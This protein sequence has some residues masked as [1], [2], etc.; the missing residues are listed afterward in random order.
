MAQTKQAKIFASLR[1]LLLLPIPALWC[2]LDHYGKL[3]FL[4]N[5]SVDWRFQVRGEIEAP[6]KIVYA[7]I[8][9]LSLNQIGGFPW[10]RSY[11]ATVAAAL[12]NEAKVKAVG[13]DVVFSDAGISESVNRKKLVEGNAE[14]GRYLNKQPPVVLAAAYGGWQFLDVNGKRKERALPIMAK[15][16]RK[17]DD[18]EPPETPSFETSPDPDKRRPYTPPIAVGLIDTMGGGTRMVPAWTPSNIKKTYYHMSLELARLYWGLPAG[19][20]SHDANQITFKNPDGSVFTTVPLV[21]GQLLEINWFTQW[22]SPQIA[23]TTHVEFS[24]LYTYA[25]A[26]ASKDPEEVKAGKEFFAQG[27]FKDAVVLVGPVDPLLQDVAPTSMDDGPVP[28]VSV[29]GNLLKTIVSEQFLRHLEPRWNYFIVFGLAIVVTTLAVAGGARALF[30][31]VM[32]VLTLVVFLAATFHLFKESHIV[33]P[34]TA[35]LGAALTMS[36][37]GLIWQVIDEQKAKGRIKG[38]FGAYVSP[39]LVDRMIDSGEDPQLGGHDDEI[40]AYFS[41]IQGFSSFSE[42]L[43]SGPLVELM[44]E[45][46]TACTDIVQAQGGTLDKYIGDAVVAMFGAPIPLPDHAYRACVATQLV[47]QKL[48]ELREKWKHEGEKWPEIVWK[49]QSRIGLNTGVCMIGNMG[50]R[51]R[52]NYTMMGDN[53]NLAARMESGAKS[54]GA[55][56]MVAEAAKLGCQKHDNGRVVF[57][58]LGRIQVMGRS[59]AVPIF[60]I[61]GLKESLAP[62]APECIGLFEQGLARY[63]ARDW[64]G[65]I[66]LFKQSVELE[67]NQPGKTPGVKTNPSLVYIGIAEHYKVVP[68][69]SNWEGVYVMTEK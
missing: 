45:Y 18:I 46:L 28:K 29:H 30:A 54:W 64:D 23:D 67:P 12:V 13:F 55:Y 24:T 20:I 34:F 66:A 42:K 17:L 48:G 9:T 47:H 39:Q 61:V 43:G 3:N 35:P 59:Q 33:L 58:A 4:E 11:F 56:T 65:A 6:L 2:V 57:R 27:E 41:D 8:D 16:T 25:A 26:L 38:M 49:M 69:P 53:V 63:Y 19:S 22:Y 7:D 60:E 51:T 62:T 37:A 52:F 10:S 14:F 40:T 15:E 1:W 44:N 32:A 50:S 5:R 68:P 36:F 31:K 21:Q